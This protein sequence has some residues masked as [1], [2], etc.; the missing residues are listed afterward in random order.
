MSKTGTKK[1][2]IVLVGGGDPLLTSADL[3]KL[4]R[5]TAA[6]LAATSSTGRAPS[7][8]R[9]YVNDTLFPAPSRAKGWRASY[10][11]GEIS[12]VRALGRRGV[13]SHD[14]TRDAQQYFAAQLRT[15]GIKVTVAGRTSQRSGQQV[16]RLAGRRVDAAV[17]SMLLVSDNQIAETL[18]RQVALHTGRAATWKGSSRA[19]PRRPEEGGRADREAGAGRRQRL[20]ALEPADRHGTGQDRAGR[21]GGVVDDGR[22]KRLRAFSQGLPVAGRSGTLTRRFS[23]PVASCARGRVLAKTGFLDGVVSLSGVAQGHRRPQPRVLDRREPDPDLALLRRAD[24]GRGR[25][26]RSGRHRLPL[27]HR[28]R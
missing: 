15:T 27:T 8:V 7:S 1:N 18:F 4:A 9:L 20:V 17:T 25:R 3:R 12:P 14:T 6:G 26:S 2:R 5:R 24:P 21:L 10:G 22:S 16:A 28:D 23:S 19:S 13:A 11:L